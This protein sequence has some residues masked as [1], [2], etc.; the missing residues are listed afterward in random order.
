[1]WLP[2]C[3]RKLDFAEEKND[4]IKF[5]AFYKGDIKK[6]ALHS[7]GLASCI[8]RYFDRAA[9]LLSDENNTL[10]RVSIPSD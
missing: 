3:E 1:M 6:A 4:V 9:W 5:R 7:A 8:A 10:Y 2:M